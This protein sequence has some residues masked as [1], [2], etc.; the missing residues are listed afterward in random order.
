MNS[1]VAAILK[2][3]FLHLVVGGLLVSSMHFV[4]KPKPKV[5]EVSLPVINAVS[6]DKAVVEKQLQNIRDKKEAIKRAEREKVQKE[7]R[8]VEAAKRKQRAE[9]KR[10]AEEKRKKEEAAKRAKAEK[11]RKKKEKEA[12]RKKEQ[13]RK[14]KEAQQKKAA[15]KKKR[16]R[17]EKRRKEQ[18][19][20]KKREAEER[21]Q[22][23][24]L[25]QEQLQAEQAARQNR[26]RQKQVLTE[27]QKY[28]AL[29][30]QTIQRNLIV[31]DSMRG[32]SCR[33]NIKLASNG[34]V[35]SVKVLQGDTYLCRAAESAVLKATTLP[36]SSEPDVYE[37][38]KNINLTVEPDL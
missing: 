22:Q 9:A 18:E 13:E 11:L 34:L 15:E 27:V 33:L 20:R 25:L 3:V 38:M 2:S 1:S 8:R 36:M 7:K 19:A 29:I 35:L 21:K 32:K 17:E 37:K 26:K 31:D 5:I 24:K 16:D 14:K 6:V 12:A 10:K 23:E 28:E 30:K 4:S